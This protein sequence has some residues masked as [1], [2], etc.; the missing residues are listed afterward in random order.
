MA[1]KSDTL[2]DRI[3]KRLKNNR[4]IAIAVV[5]GGVVVGVAQFTESLGKIISGIGSGESNSSEFCDVL[6]PLTAQLDRTKDAF[7]RWTEPNLSLEETIIKPANEEARNI[8]LKNSH[9]VAT[10]LRNDAQ[11]LVRHYDCWLEE[12][13][14]QRV[15]QGDTGAAFV[16][17]APKGCGFP[18]KSEQR[19][20]ER[21]KELAT[22]YDGENPCA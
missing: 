7:N 15:R 22:K 17:V 20:R 5:T 12:Y 14:R 3:W 18:S 13:N 16:F 8:L 21:L 9:L 2:V 6:L 11:K 1:N 19:F 10:H 4:V